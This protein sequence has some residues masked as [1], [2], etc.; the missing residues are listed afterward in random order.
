MWIKAVYNSAMQA[1]AGSGDFC[2]VYICFFD[3][4]FLENQCGNIKIG[5]CVM[6]F[7]AKAKGA[8]VSTVQSPGM[9]CFTRVFANASHQTQC[10]KGFHS[11]ER[12]KKFKL[13]KKAGKF[14]L[15]GT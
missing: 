9:A 5:N 3:K 15:P 1:C 12:I 6:P 8:R 14:R 4:F 13:D 7:I 11:N 2:T 10:G